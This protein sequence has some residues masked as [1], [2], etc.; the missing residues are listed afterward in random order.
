MV[1]TG[2]FDFKMDLIFRNMKLV[3][4]R[5]KAGK[6]E[7]LKGMDLSGVRVIIIT[8]EDPRIN[9]F[10]IFD[11][12]PGEAFIIRSFEFNVTK[13]VQRT[14][15]TLMMIADIQK[16]I[17]LGHDDSISSKID[18]FRKNYMKF[19][20]NFPKR[21]PY[22]H[23]LK[24]WE[25]AK[26]FLRIHEPKNID[27]V[28]KQLKSL[29]F[30]RDMKPHVEIEPMFF[31]LA[32]WHVYN[33][34]EIIELRGLLINDCTLDLSSFI[35][36]RFEKF[37]TEHEKTLFPVDGEK[38]AAFQ[39]ES[40]IHAQMES[41]FADF[42]LGENKKID[43]TRE[44]PGLSSMNGSHVPLM[45]EKF[46]SV[47]GND[48]IDKLG[49]KLQDLSIE[50]NQDMDVAM[51]MNETKDTIKSVE[52]QGEVSE[53]AIAGEMDTKDRIITENVT[54]SLNIENSGLSGSKSGVKD[55]SFSSE[56]RDLLNSK[57]DNLIIK[58]EINIP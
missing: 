21:S 18:I 51:P 6:I 23:A 32:N 37:K 25:N 30:V 1:K 57:T 4:E 31:N 36:A 42:D 13:E 47:S 14:I 17:I 15:I 53:P 10:D 41:S 8:S 9:P 43:S 19:M 28:F 35:P 50:L 26:R 34:D 16:I 7:D 27:Y 40:S 44:K 49:I 20:K 24:D 38:E 45:E 33:R 58:D 3:L 48:I 12:K 39:T 11:L 55:D 46:L 52:I 5:T 54:T 29:N 22:W 56:P 2:G